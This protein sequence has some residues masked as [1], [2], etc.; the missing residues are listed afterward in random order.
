MSLGPFVAG[1]NFDPENG[2]YCGDHLELMAQLPNNSIGL[3]VTSPPY[4]GMRNYEGYDFNFEALVSQLWRVTL[5]GGVVVWVVGDQTKDGTESGTSF[6]QALHFKDVGF[7]LHDTMIF[8]KTGGGAVGSNLCYLQAF[9]YMFIFSKGRPRTTSLIYDRKNVRPGKGKTSGGRR[10]RT[11]ELTPKVTVDSKKMGRRFNIWKYAQGSVAV[12]QKQHPA[13]FPV[14]LAYDHI[15]SWSAEDGIIFDPMAGSG[16]TAKAAV[17]AGRK[18]LG[19][20]VAQKYV[21][22]ARVWLRQW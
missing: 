7:N 1:P 15:I 4:D 21:D 13:V 16:T 18:Y 17:R 9:E 5:Q 20:D 22:A 2:F 19:F 11:G 12:A 6:R 14:D 8:E 10:C 3:T